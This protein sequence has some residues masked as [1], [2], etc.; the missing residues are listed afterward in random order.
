MQVTVTIEDAGDSSKTLL[1]ESKGDGKVR[2]AAGGEVRTVEGSLVERAIQNGLNVG[3]DPNPNLLAQTRITETEGG[4]FLVV[5]NHPEDRALVAVK[6]GSETRNVN[7]RQ[8]T[9]GIRHCLNAS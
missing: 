6:A 8:F 4:A 5:E 1:L 2:I 3:S 7:G 9:T